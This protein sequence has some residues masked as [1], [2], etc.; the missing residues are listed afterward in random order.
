MNKNLSSPTSQLTER[1]SATHSL[2]QIAL[3]RATAL[4]EKEQIPLDRAIIK[5]GLMEEDDLLPE[6][7]ASLG[8][9]YFSDQS[10]LT[11]DTDRLAVLSE[12]FCRDKSVVP[13]SE[14][15][16][17]A[18]VLT[19]DPANHS[20][21]EE[22]N[23]F[24][25]GDVEI[26]VAPVRFIRACLMMSHAHPEPA[27][28][29]LSADLL[30]ADQ[31][32]L[33][34]SKTD[35]PVIRFVA[36]VFSQAV[37]SGASDIH[38]EAQEDGLRIRLRHNGVLHIHPVDPAL[39]V[40]SILARV[41]VMAGLNVSERRLPQ[42][43]RITS[44]IAGRKVD[45][46]VSSVP[47]S[48]GESIVA[49]V[50]DPKALRLGWEKLGFDPVTQTQIIS[51]IEQ[52]SGLFLVTGPTGSGKTTT[53]YTAL[54]HLNHDG[55]KI[56]TVEDPVEYNLSG[57]EQVQVHE[58]IGMTFAKALRSFLRQDPNIIMVGEIR[59]HETAEIACRAALVGRMV[60]STLHTNTPEDAITRLTDLGVAPYVVK[61]VLKGVLGQK[62]DVVEGQ[63]R[64][65]SARFVAFGSS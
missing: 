62:L 34:A 7:A 48:F 2:P 26:A 25:D 42:D 11:I 39:S 14:S 46:R 12:P 32:V 1:L 15:S 64:Q 56:L 19:N 55:Q 38:F 57:V 65:L 13:V 29:D 24:F 54:A 9:Q 10:E 31:Q 5:L 47:T 8:L 18:V 51:A 59:D 61:D 16:G 53:L 37:S 35:G 44:N 49:R 58:E 17:R 33:R 30:E 63:P 4:A 20:L 3:A 22:L 60:L 41:K 40:A 27:S 36:D 6:L 52:P 23:F 43:G 50:L 21:L 28:H 45:F